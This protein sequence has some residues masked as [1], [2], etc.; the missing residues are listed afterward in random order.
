MLTDH[1]VLYLCVSGWMKVEQRVEPAKKAAQVLHKKLQ[2]CM[3]S[4]SGLEAEKRMVLKLPNPGGRVPKHVIGYTERCYVC[5]CPHRKSSLWCCCPSA[6]QRASKTLMQ[7]PLLGDRFDSPSLHALDLNSRL[8][9]LLTA[10][11]WKPHDFSLVVF[12]FDERKEDHTHP[13]SLW[14]DF[15]SCFLFIVVRLW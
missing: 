11:M 12:S 14:L 15:Y 3:Q 8:V 10:V 5:F 2:A 7:I 13:D 1:I 4:Q 6:W 9:A